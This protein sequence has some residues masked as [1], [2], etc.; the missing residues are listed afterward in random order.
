MLKLYIITYETLENL[1]KAKSNDDDD[2][3]DSTTQGK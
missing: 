2:D 1:Q 3:D